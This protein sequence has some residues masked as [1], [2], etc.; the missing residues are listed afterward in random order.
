MPGGRVD[1]RTVI[2]GAVGAA[3]FAGAAATSAVWA[4]LNRGRHPHGFDPGLGGLLPSAGDGPPFR[5][6]VAE[7]DITPGSGVSMIGYGYKPRMS[8]GR[9]ARRLRAQCVVLRDADGKALTLVRV[10]AGALT[11][12]V[13]RSIVDTLVAEKTIAG[14]ADFMLN[15]SH[16]HSGPA[17]GMHPD[18]RVL[19]SLPDTGLQGVQATAESFR[20]KVIDLVR[21]AHKAEGV[22]VFLAHAVGRAEVG[23]QR[24]VAEQSGPTEL[25]VLVARNADGGKV[26]AVIYSYPCH[27]V[28]RG[29]DN[30][31]DADFC[32]VASTAISAEL[33]APALFLQGT[34]GNIDPV[35]R[36]G[37]EPRVHLVGQSLADAVLKTV[38]EAKFNRLKGGLESAIDEVKLPFAQDLSNS[39]NVAELRRRYAER[40]AQLPVGATKVGAARRHAE[41]MVQLIDTHRL[42]AGVEMTTQVWRLGGLRIAAMAHEA[43][44][45][46]SGAVR[47]LAGSDDLWVLGY[48]NHVE[49]YLPDD[50]SL[51]V[52]GYAA[53]WNETSGRY[54]PGEA[55]SVMIYGWPAPLRSTLDAT[56]NMPCAEAMILDRMGRLLRL[57]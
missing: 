5:L 44:D 25:P 6:T 56:A 19:T 55:G 21:A 22:Q 11:Y 33:Q 27:P 13:Y 54:F 49:C 2:V 47:R 14:L 52:G 45:Y 50:Q 23:V 57:T 38:R 43:V 28:C 48:T 12:E 37:G 17:L 18:P 7:V 35:G 34:G 26:E 41:L 46:Y 24:W 1:R 15:V 36:G 32:G 53:G 30:V 29:N 39:A 8:N 9:C 10:D 40:V 16:T 3:V 51:R 31:F 20:T 42:P 4:R